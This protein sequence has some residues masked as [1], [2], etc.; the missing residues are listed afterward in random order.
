V[1]DERESSSDLQATLFDLAERGVLRLEGH[2]TR[3]TV[4]TLVDTSAVEL[5]PAERAVLDAFDLRVA[6]SS[7]TVSRSTGAGEKIAAARRA[8]RMQVN[9]SA[10]NHLHTSAAGVVAMVLGWAALASV[11]AM[12]GIYFFGETAWVSWPLLV[13]AA[14]FAFI[15]M[16]MM[17][18]VGV[19]TKR[20][21]QGRD[22]WSRTGG[23]ARFLTTESSESRFDAAAHRDWYPRY[24]AWAVALGAA[25]AWAQRY[26]AQGV[27]IPEVPWMA[28]TGGGQTQ[29]FSVPRMNSAFNSAI[30]GASA[31][32]A[33][34]QS[35]SG[36]SGGGFSG[37]SGGGGGGGG[38]W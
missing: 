19:V 31:A 28:W 27:E 21:A 13:G 17:F 23:F 7:F 38:S 1:L 20:T 30:A 37:G 3:W 9:A 22:L 32:Y 35:S 16:G 33:A 10:R 18:D 29:H 4:H 15:A 25:D 34:S 11:I 6:G 12:A 14:V 24:L 36:G 26:E 8:L 2:D 5:H